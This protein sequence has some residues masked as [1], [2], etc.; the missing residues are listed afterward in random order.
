MLK[1]HASPEIRLCMP[2]HVQFYEGWKPR[3]IF[4]LKRP[5]WTIVGDYSNTNVKPGCFL[6]QDVSLR[7]SAL[8]FTIFSIPRIL[9]LDVPSAA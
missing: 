9:F 3:Y 8:G 2:E 6:S 4:S 1:M 5:L 7:S